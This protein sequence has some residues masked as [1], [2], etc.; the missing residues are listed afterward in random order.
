[1][2]TEQSGSGD[3]NEAVNMITEVLIEAKGSLEA[4]TRSRNCYWQGIL[5]KK[6]AHS[7]HVRSKQTTSKI[8]CQAAVLAGNEVDW[9]HGLGE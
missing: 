4:A 7:I 5:F 9:Q 8:G 1:M 2:L 3:E 6:Y